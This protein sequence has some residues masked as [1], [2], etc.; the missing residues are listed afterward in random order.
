MFTKGMWKNTNLYCGYHE[1]INDNTLMQLTEN[2]GQLY[3]CC[4]LC[5]NLISTS[6]FETLLNQISKK[7]FNN[8]K[9]FSFDSLEGEKFT[10]GKDRI[11]C[12]IIK[13][14]DNAG[15]DIKVLN[16]KSRLEKKYG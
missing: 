15:F 14:N 3:Y 12:E 10:V 4:P 11:K 6:C 1:D 9:D 13:E 16:P 5:K 8:I 7:S 2:R